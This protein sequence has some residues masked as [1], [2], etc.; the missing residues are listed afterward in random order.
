MSNAIEPVYAWAIYAPPFFDIYTGEHY[1]PK[2]D[3]QWQQE[4]QRWEMRSFW[5]TN[6]EHDV[7][8][9]RQVTRYDDEEIAD[10]FDANYRDATRRECEVI[11][12]FCSTR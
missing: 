9:H 5:D 11:T 10:W 3:H 2:N 6:E 7:K 1:G 12:A 8:E 4:N